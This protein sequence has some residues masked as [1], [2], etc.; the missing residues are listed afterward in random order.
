MWC[1][2]CPFCADHVHGSVGT[3]RLLGAGYVESMIGTH[4]A[5]HVDEMVAEAVQ[6]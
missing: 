3:M 6:R 5:V 1:W 2:R 4:L